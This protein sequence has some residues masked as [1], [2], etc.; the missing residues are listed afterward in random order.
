MVVFGAL[1]VPWSIRN[2]IVTNGEFKGI[3]SNAPAE[4][5]RATSM[6][7]QSTTFSA[8]I[9][10]GDP[11]KEQWDPEANA[12]E[13][14]L[15]QAHGGVFYRDSRD[16]EG[17]RYLVPA[18]A[19][20]RTSADLELER[21]RIES[22]EMKRK[23]L[24]EPGAFVAKFTVQLFTF[25]YIVET[26]T[27]SL[28]VGIVALVVLSLAAIGYVRASGVA[29][30]C[31]RSPCGALLQCNLRSVPGLRAL[32]HAALPYPDHPGCRRA[33]DTGS[34]AAEA[35]PAAH[36]RRGCRRSLAHS[37]AALPPGIRGGTS[38]QGR[39]GG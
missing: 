36:F 34:N 14:Q 30:W 29:S 10:G 27:K 16:A 39:L 8:R 23:L 7:S 33:G 18:P 6:P 15:L 2:A 9:S 35:V 38:I 22:K 5:L 21:D 3:S 28:F 37:R 25:W 31:G 11:T 32:L 12:Y 17:H 4:F 24:A 1:L 20:G 13:D 26:R 19:P